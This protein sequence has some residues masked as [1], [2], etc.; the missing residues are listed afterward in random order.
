MFPRIQPFGSDEL[1][2]LGKVYSRQATESVNCENSS[3]SSVMKHC[4]TSN[5]VRNP[6]S[7]QIL[8]TCLVVI[9]F[10]FVPDI[11]AIDLLLVQ[12]R[13]SKVCLS[14]FSWHEQWVRLSCHN[15]SP[16][17]IMTGVTF[18][19]HLGDCSVDTELID[20]KKCAKNSFNCLPIGKEVC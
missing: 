9:T 1:S 15:K 12:D 11:F 2:S 7:V 18:F 13:H 4:P 6:A 20:G 17:S 8:I 3:V 10:Q 16:G 19:A 14:C 5:V